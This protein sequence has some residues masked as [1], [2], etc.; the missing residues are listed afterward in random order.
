MSN[1]HAVHC[2]TGSEIVEKGVEEAVLGEHAT[3]KQ[4][5]RITLGVWL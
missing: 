4:G 3:K 5:Q 2:Y 1:T